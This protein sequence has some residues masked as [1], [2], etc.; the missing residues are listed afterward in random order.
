MLNIWDFFQTFK[1][2][3]L[4]KFLYILCIRLNTIETRNWKANSTKRSWQVDGQG[5]I[6]INL[7]LL[8]DLFSRTVRARHRR[9]PKQSREQSS[10]TQ[11]KRNPRSRRL[12]SNYRKYTMSSLESALKAVCDGVLNITGA[13]AHYG[14]PKSTIGDGLK[15]RLSLEDSKSVD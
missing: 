1:Y 9:K 2:F 6:Q 8:C 15:K 4:C 13:S 11:L 12:G 10:S 3:L 5:L 7:I 14:V